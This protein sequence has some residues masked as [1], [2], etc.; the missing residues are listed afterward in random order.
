M[1]SRRRCH[2]GGAA[3]TLVVGAQHRDNRFVVN[4]AAIDDVPD[5]DDGS[6]EDVTTMST[7]T[8]ASWDPINSAACVM[9]GDPSRTTY[10]PRLNHLHSLP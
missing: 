3:A 6:A 9:A 7:R 1:G 2:T 10:R 5:M 4:A 8:S